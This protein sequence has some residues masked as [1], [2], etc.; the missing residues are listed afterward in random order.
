MRIPEIKINAY[1]TIIILTFLF[2]GNTITNEYALDDAIVIT[3]NQF[4]KYGF[5][6]ADHPKKAA[7]G[8]VKRIKDVYI[9]QISPAD[10]TRIYAQPEYFMLNVK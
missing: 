7:A 10:K 6:V 5:S 9:L 4:T 1:L 8:L 2:Y 3:Q